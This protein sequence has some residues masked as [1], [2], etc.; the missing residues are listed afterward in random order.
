MAKSVCTVKPMQ[1]GIRVENYI[2]R[3]YRREA[4]DPDRVVGTV[5]CVE[6]RSHRP[7]HGLHS[8]GDLL[9]DAGIVTIAEAKK[10]SA[11]VSPDTTLIDAGV[12]SE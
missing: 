5:E 2:V 1:M 4:N 6:T 12:K 9:A 7:F 11:S 8:L 3:I 10:P